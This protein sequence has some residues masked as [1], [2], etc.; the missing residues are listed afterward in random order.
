MTE[1]LPDAIT[2]LKF[3][4]LPEEIRIGEKIFMDIQALLDKTRLRMHG[5]L[6]KIINHFHFWVFKRE[7]LKRR[8]EFQKFIP[9]SLHEKI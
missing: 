9:L 2:L 3:W 7:F 5:G 8:R 1:Q 6:S 4:H